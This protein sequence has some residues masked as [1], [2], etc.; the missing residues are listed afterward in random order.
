M[1]R[2]FDVM[3]RYPEAFFCYS[4]AVTEE[5]YN[6]EFWYRL[7][8]HYWGA[9]HAGKKPSRHFLFPAPVRTAGGDSGVAETALRQLPEMQGVPLPVPGTNPLTSPTEPPPETLP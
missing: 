9:R 6:G 4:T 1:G 3:R 5:P 8:N 7:G 2:T